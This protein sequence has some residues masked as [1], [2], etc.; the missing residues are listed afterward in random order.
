ME[1]A[2]LLGLILIGPG[3]F[4]HESLRVRNASGRCRIVRFSV[5]A[6]D[7]PKTTPPYVMLVIAAGL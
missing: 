6:R 5:P 2:K 1:H 7:E 3:P 4:Y